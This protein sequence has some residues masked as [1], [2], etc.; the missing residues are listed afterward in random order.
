MERSKLEEGSRRSPTS[1]KDD[2]KSYGLMKRSFDDFIFQDD[3]GNQAPGRRLS[4]RGVYR[5]HVPDAFLQYYPDDHRTSP[6][7]FGVRIIINYPEMF[8]INF[9]RTPLLRDRCK[10]PDSAPM[11]L[12][13]AG[14]GCSGE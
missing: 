11:N 13:R 10:G 8:E 4:P 2:S 6:V 1:V 9:S 7:V 12:A 14:Y 3:C 5:T